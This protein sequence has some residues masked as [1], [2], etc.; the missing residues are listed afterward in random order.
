MNISGAVNKNNN[1]NDNFSGEG[2]LNMIKFFHLK[3]WPIRV[4]T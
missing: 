1:K 2:T 4:E 3:Y